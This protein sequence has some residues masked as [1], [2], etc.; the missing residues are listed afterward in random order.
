MGRTSDA[1]ERLIQAAID[2][3]WTASYGAV[4]VDAICDRAGVKKGS[5]YHFFSGKDDLMVAAL[6]A[7]WQSRR[8]VFD[9]TFSPSVDPLTRLRHY[10]T[11]VFE[12]Q[13][14]VQ[15]KYGRVLGCFHN[16]VGTE[17]IQ[18]LP[19][20]AAKVQEV[21][22]SYRL[23]LE[24]TLRDAQA[25]G[26]MRAGDPAADA[27]MLFAYVEGALTQARI[28]DDPTI[29]QSL[30]EAGFALLGIRTSP[31]APAPLPLAVPA[32]VPAKRSKRP[33]AAKTTRAART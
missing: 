27:K 8:A 15:A 21:L 26:A 16:S 14:A 20:I 4:G 23:Y 33:A 7:H 10:F 12:R 1:R 22:S 5:F 18:A 28:H 2:L 31:P 11:H 29:L 3:V 6:D 32:A 13:V 17:C 25:V 24:T 30:P 9:A 19:A